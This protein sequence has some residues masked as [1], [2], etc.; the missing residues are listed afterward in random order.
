MSNSGTSSQTQTLPACARRTSTSWTRIGS[1]SA[2]A[3]VARRSALATETRAGRPAHST[4]RPA[5]RFCFGASVRSTVIYGTLASSFPDTA[6]DS[7]RRSWEGWPSFTRSREGEAMEELQRW[8]RVIAPTVLTGGL[9]VALVV[10]TVATTGGPLVRCQGLRPT[11]QGTNGNDALTGT[12]G[13]DVIQA[14]AGADVIDGRGGPDLICAAQGDDVARGGGGAGH[15][16]P[17]RRWR[18]RPRRGW[19]GHRARRTQRRPDHRRRR[20]GHPQWARRPGQG[21]RRIRQ[22]PALRRA[23]QRHAAG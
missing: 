10:P 7:S 15:D 13:R 3:S 19:P 14:R 18:R 11:I 2:L 4:A 16:L 6:L 12:P 1:A 8:R 9:I 20:S 5:G 22:R 23:W 21:L 17:R